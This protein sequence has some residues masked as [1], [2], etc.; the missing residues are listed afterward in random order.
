MAGV[1]DEIELEDAIGIASFFVATGRAPGP[2]QWVDTLVAGRE[3]AAMAGI[4]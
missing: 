2:A 4:F 3:S 1:N